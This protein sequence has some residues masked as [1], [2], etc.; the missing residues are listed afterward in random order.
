MKWDIIF[1]WNLFH[2]PFVPFLFC[3]KFNNFYFP[4]NL[5]IKNNTLKFIIPALISHKLESTFSTMISIIKIKK[6]LHFNDGLCIN[7][8]AMNEKKILHHK[9]FIAVYNSRIKQFFFCCISENCF[10]SSHKLPK[11]LSRATNFRLSQLSAFLC[12]LINK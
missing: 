7:K 6:K 10:P 12:L 5:K 1:N 4:N 3:F 2:F 11:Y 8:I 9:Y